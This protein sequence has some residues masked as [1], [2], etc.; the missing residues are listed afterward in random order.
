MAPHAA[1]SPKSG[2][3]SKKDVDPKLVD[4][5]AA[6][7]CNIEEIAAVCKVSRDTIERR[8]RDVIEAGKANGRASLRRLQWRAAEVDRNPT[9]LIWLGKQY[10]GQ[11]DEQHIRHGLDPDSPEGLLLALAG[12]AVPGQTKVDGDDEEE[13]HE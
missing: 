10:L 4:R 6:I 8:F 13:D 2:R 1:K 3:F 7:H 5:L 9:M 11:R 12:Q